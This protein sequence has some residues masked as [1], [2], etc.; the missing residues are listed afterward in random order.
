MTAPLT[1]KGLW[2]P[3]HR[4]KAGTEWINW[5]Y[6]RSTKRESKR[7][8]LADFIAPANVLSCTRFAR[9]VVTEVSGG[10]A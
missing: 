9:V 7:A 5:A 4:T 1:A 8:L 10:V 3:V 2:A 6:V